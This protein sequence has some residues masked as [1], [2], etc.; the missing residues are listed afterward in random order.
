[1]PSIRAELM[2]LFC[3]HLSPYTDTCVCR[4]TGFMIIHRHSAKW[5]HLP[6]LHDSC[7]RVLQQL[8]PG[9]IQPGL[10]LLT[11]LPPCSQV[12]LQGIEPGL[13]RQ[14]GTNGPQLIPSC[15][16][17]L[18]VGKGLSHAVLLAV[19]QHVCDSNPV[20]AE[21]EH[22]S[23]K[24]VLNTDCRFEGAQLD[25]LAFTS[26]FPAAMAHA[27]PVFPPPT[28]CHMLLWSHFIYTNKHQGSDTAC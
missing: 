4:H 27:W 24:Q 2:T 13:L 17:Q 22:V 8:L 3:V 21:T 19:L 28:M 23:P 26:A 7:S 9:C 11:F 16:I 25:T 1:M 12:M 10:L 20:R 6:V 18:P 15:K 5:A 14:P